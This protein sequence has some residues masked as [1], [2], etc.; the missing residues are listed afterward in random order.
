MHADFEGVGV[1]GPWA[2]KNGYRLTCVKPYVREVL[3]AADGFDFLVV[4]GGPQS[5]LEKD[6]FPYL[7][8]E[9]TLIR[10]F[11][12]QDKGVVGFCLGAQLLGEA[13]GAPAEKSPEKEV[14]IYPITLTER[15]RQDA[16]FL[17]FPHSFAVIHWHYDMPGSTSQSV[18]LAASAGCP[19]QIVRY[20]PKAYGFQCHLEIT[21]EGLALLA[22]KAARD[23]TPSLYTQSKDIL[24]SHPLTE[25]HHKMDLILDRFVALLKDA[26]SHQYDNQR[27]QG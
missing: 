9:I 16:L 18:V 5:P 27:P 6:R 4:M 2:K 11:L 8:D 19:R 14:G 23:L 20:G 12:D 17:D 21:Q 1:I 7:G 3:P 24:L 15:G 13:L 26:S 25:I 22:D 10:S